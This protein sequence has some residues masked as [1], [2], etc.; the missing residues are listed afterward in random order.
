MPSLLRVSLQRPTS[1]GNH[2]CWTLLIAFQIL[3]VANFAGAE[4]LKIGAVINLTGPAAFM[5]V[6]F[7]DGFELCTQGKIHTIYEDHQ[8]QA[9]IGVSA[10]NKLVNVDHINLGLVTFSGVSDGIIPIAARV[11]VPLF[12]TIVSSGKVAKR[13]G[14]NV[15]NFFTTAEQDGPLMADFL[16]TRMK[17]S[18]AAVLYL[19]GE[20][21]ESYADAFQSELESKG[22][23]VVFREN[24]TPSDTDFRS[25]LLKAKKARA[26]ALYF[27]AY[28]NHMLSLIRQSRELNLGIKLA[29]CWSISAPQTRRGNESIL[30]GVI[31]TAPAYYFSKDK[32]VADFAA[33]FKE[34]YGREPTAYAAE[35]C[36]AGRLFLEYGKLVPRDLIKT[37]RELKDFPGILGPLTAVDGAIEF[38]LVPVEVRNG[39]LVNLE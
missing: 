17:V 28:D 10:F 1:F 26:E 22:G 8:T 39:E 21:G 25:L 34:H 3:V 37:F 13:G 20:F 19:A 16:A 24:F 33:H 36:D 31:S 23:Q 30:E 5:G 14:E 15:V 29:G 18:K 2:Y 12:L 35:G 27:A 11:H 7:R 38:P 32:M 9:A 6:D 4:D